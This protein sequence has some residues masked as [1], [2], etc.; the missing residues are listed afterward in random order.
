MNIHEY[1]GK[2][3]FKEYGV[4][5]PN[6]LL[7][8]EED[9]LEHAL[10]RIETN[11][12]VIK[13][14]VHTGGRGK[15]GGVKL[16]KS[17]TEGLEVGR[18]MLGKRLVTHQTTD[19]G[20]LVRQVYIEEGC[21]IDKEYYLSLVL[22]RA[23]NC[24]TLIASENGGMDIEEVAE[25]QPNSILKMP[26]DVG[27][28]IKDY[29]LSSLARTLNLPQAVHREFI[30]VVKSLYALY[31]DRDCLM[32]EVNPLV[33]T[34]DESLIALDAKI[35]FDDNALYRQEENWYL[36]DI[37][38]MNPRE[39]E[40]GEYG[41]SYIALEG[42]IACMVNGAGLAMA[43]LD[44]IVA[45]GGKPANFLDVGGSATSDN[46]GKAMEIIMSDEQVKGLFINIFGGIMKCDIVAEGLL[47][48]TSNKEI[49]MP[50]VVRLE[51]TREEEGKALLLN[52]SLN[53]NIVSSFD[54]GAQTIVE[55]CGGQ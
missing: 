25:N 26:I 5:V 37:H 40:A 9:Q 24:V 11:V 28:G 55:L 47:K 2:A 1:Q 18:Q 45:A 34:E 35:D 19:E 4:P 51:G 53:V 23:E 20:V 43:T 13:A 50:I 41:L 14:Q 21:L 39:V 31:M 16:V 54:E 38:E 29:E 49:T 22:D 33:L 48:A 27:Y 8:K 7:V 46:I 44:G 15:A 36:R 12:A 30:R 17:F 32:I 10:R 6:G 42:D 3:L 52:S